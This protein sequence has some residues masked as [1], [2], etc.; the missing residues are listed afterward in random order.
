VLI[1]LRSNSIKILTRLNDYS[2]GAYFIGH[3]IYLG[4]YTNRKDSVPVDDE[5]ADYCKANWLSTKPTQKHV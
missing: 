4:S 5:D 1:V 2:T 3:P